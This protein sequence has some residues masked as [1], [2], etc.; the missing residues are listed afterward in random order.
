MDLVV[1]EV[2]QLKHVHDS[3]HYLVRHRLSGAA[4]IYRYLAVVAHLGILV[5][6][7]PL[8]VWGDILSRRRFE[9]RRYHLIAPL[10]RDKTKH[11]F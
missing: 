8:D 11:R 9:D 3:D 4:V 1:D 10:H 7:Y 5:L 2:Y 6:L